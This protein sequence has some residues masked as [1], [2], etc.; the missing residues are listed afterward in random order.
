MDLALKVESRW[1]ANILRSKEARAMIRSLFLSMGELNKGARRPKSEP[2]PKIAQGRRAR[3]GLH[4]RGHRLCRGAERARRRADRP[5][6]GVGRQGQGAFAQADVRTRS[7]RAAPR[8]RTR[9]RCWRA[10]RRRDDYAALDGCDLVIEAVF[11][12]RAVK[13]EATKKA[14][15][16]DAARRRLRSQ[17]L[18]AAD[19]VARRELRP[20]PETSSASISSRR[21]RR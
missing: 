8:P 16:V 6:H 1:F 4:G 2:Q 14:Q 15:A 11:E 20:Q 19:H 10:S 12:D 9:T 21:S 5:R 13:A 3:R 7:P 17:H 18:D